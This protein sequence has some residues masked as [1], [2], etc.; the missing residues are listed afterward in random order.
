MIKIIVKVNAPKT[1]ILGFDKQKNVYKVAV[2]AKPLEG[3]ANKEIINFFSK[4]L[5]KRVMI[6]RGLK[7]K[8]KVLK[9]L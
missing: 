4:K 7:S 6:V 8:E 5:K 2:K 3:K 1:E 9:I